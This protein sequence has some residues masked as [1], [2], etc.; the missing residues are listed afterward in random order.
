MLYLKLDSQGLTLDN[1][2]FFVYFF[3]FFW[4]TLNIAAGSSTGRV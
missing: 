2:C 4:H 1:P 3:I